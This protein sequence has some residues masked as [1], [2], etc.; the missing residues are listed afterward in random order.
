[1]GTEMHLI[2]TCII[3]IINECL[4]NLTDEWTTALL[5]YEIVLY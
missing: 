5:A 3:I 4:W 2:R 1:M